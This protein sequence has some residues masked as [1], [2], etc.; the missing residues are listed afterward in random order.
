MSCVV[1]S[2]DINQTF[3]IESLPSSISGCTGIYTN[4]L[5]SCSGDTSI[6]LGSGIIIFDGSIYTNQ[7]LTAN[8][9]NSNFYYSGGTP[10]DVIIKNTDISGGTFDD[11]TGHLTLKTYDNSQIL[12]TGFTDYYTTGATIEN[13]TIYFNRNDV[14]SAYTVSL[15]GLSDVYSTGVTFINNLLTITNNSGHSINTVIDNFTG[16]TVNGLITTNTVSAT[17][18]LNLPTDVRVTGGT[19]NNVNDTIIFI[20]NTGGTFSVSGLS[21]IYITGG[22]LDEV[23]KTLSYKRNDNVNIDVNLPFRLFF[24]ATA[25]TVNN[26]FITIDSV[27]GI[28]DN[29]N[30]FISS[31]ISA[32]KDNIDYGFWKRTV[33]LNKV[34]GVLQIIGENSDF[35][36]ISSGLTPNNIVYSINGGN[37]DIKI[38]GETAKNYRWSSNW[39]IIK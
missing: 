28:T 34:S 17:T 2:S 6:S 14:L 32:Y 31:Y 4:V 23:T 25:N 37:L 39:E 1:N 15:S 16:L 33:V 13:D 26:V 8:T 3:I 7:D 11:S 10:L 35:D 9:I 29:S 19:Y 24:D 30:C 21:D 22:T 38:S 12:V 5:I 18:Y 20:N 36:R 27:T